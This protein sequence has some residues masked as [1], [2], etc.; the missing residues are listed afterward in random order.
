M[1]LD[2]CP[3]N[4]VVREGVEGLAQSQAGAELFQESRE[5]RV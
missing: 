3:D 5:Y 1:G 2:N 4:Y